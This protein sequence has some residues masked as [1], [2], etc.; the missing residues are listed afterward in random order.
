MLRISTQIV[1]SNYV[2]GCL[3]WVKLISDGGEEESTYTASFHPLHTFQTEQKDTES[4]SNV[5][6]LVQP[7]CRFICYHKVDTSYSNLI[8]I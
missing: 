7:V 1:E 6:S 3:I 5:G 8:Q 4:L 2:A